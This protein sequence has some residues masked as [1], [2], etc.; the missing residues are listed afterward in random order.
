MKKRSTGCYTGKDVLRFKDESIG[1]QNVSQGKF[2]GWSPA[3]GVEATLV[4]PYN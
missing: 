4:I 1:N 2:Q 3:Q